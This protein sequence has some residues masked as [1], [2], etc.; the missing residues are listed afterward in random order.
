[1]KLAI[2]QSHRREL[3]IPLDSSSDF[4][5]NDR[6]PA[7]GIFANRSH[8]KLNP[9]A[10]FSRTW[11]P[12]LGRNSLISWSYLPPAAKTSLTFLS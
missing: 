8:A 5:K 10:C 12:A 11:P 2:K 3:K 4:F 6:P 9:T 7:L 1:M